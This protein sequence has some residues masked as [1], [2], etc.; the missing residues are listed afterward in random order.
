MPLVIA[1]REAGS[2][3]TDAHAL[4]WRTCLREVE[5]LDNE[6]AP[7]TSGRRLEEGAAYQL[8]LEILC[9]LQSPMVGETQVLGQFKAFLTTLGQEASGLRRVGQQLLTD[10]REIRAQYLQGLGSRSY[11]SAIRRDVADCPQ[12]ALVG[13]GKL[14]SEVL[15]FLLDDARH[16]DHWGRGAASA[17]VPGADVTY[18][19]LASIDAVPMSEVPTVLIIA[20]PAPAETIEAVASRYPGVRRVIDLRADIGE[21]PMRLTTPVISLQQLFDRM[22]TARQSAAPQID[23]A[24]QEIKCRSRQFELR[25]VARPFGWD[26]L[27][28]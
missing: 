19:A 2:A 1:H 22:V 7:V 10:S 25:D 23:A 13:T 9:G 24:R 3:G 26:D 12:A 27:C 4:T 15:P 21:R 17:E 18:R 8:L 20:A 16:V 5:F 14:A 6:Y 11:G 28:A